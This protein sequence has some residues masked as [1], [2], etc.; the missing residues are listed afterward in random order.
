MGGFFMLNGIRSHHTT[1][2]ALFFSNLIATPCQPNNTFKCSTIRS[3]ICLPSMLSRILET[4]PHVNS[5]IGHPSPSSFHWSFLSYYPSIRYIS[6]TPHDM[7]HPSI[8]LGI[9]QP[10]LP[11]PCVGYGYHRHLLNLL[12]WHVHH[13]KDWALKPAS[14]NAWIAWS[15]AALTLQKD[16]SVSASLPLACKTCLIFR[17]AHVTPSHCSTNLCPCTKTFLL[18]TSDGKCRLLNLHSCLTIHP[19][20]SWFYFQWWCQD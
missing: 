1:F 7:I 16:A 13:L 6:A 4:S 12:L 19:H 17:H 3:S 10:Q 11:L 9:R 8:S 14:G 5:C 18:W 2:N 15:L 20:H